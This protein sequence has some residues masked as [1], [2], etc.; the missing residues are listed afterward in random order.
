MILF[1]STTLSE[2]FHAAGLEWVQNCIIILLM[3]IYLDID[4]VILANDLQPA[5]HVNKFLSYIIDR[6]PTYWLTTHCKGDST[7]T[8]NHLARILND[9]AIKLAKRVKSTNWD[10]SKTEA[11]DWNTP[12]LWF[13]DHLFDF[14]K[15]DLVK[16]NALKSWVE[17]DL[18]ENADQLLDFVKNFPTGNQEVS[19]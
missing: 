4:G 6:H 10:F 2:T 14:E 18:S 15:E 1:N 5:K 17:V 12:F 19:I 13:D 9:D 11:I 8:V 16:H 7:Y 3:N